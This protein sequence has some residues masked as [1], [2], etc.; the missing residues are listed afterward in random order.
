M[1]LRHE[2]DEVSEE[3]KQ[4]FVEQSQYQDE[5][6][7]PDIEFDTASSTRYGCIVAVSTGTI[8]ALL[9]LISGIYFLRA[10]QTALGAAIDLSTSGQEVLALVIN[11]VLALTTDGMMFAHSVS[12]RWALY[13]EGRLE[14]NTNIRLL[15]G[16]NQFG[17]NAWYINLVA[18]A[19]LMLSYASSSVLLLS[20]QTI[21]QPEDNKET[22]ILL[23]ATALVALGIGLVVQAIIAGWSLVSSSKLIPTWSSNPLN[24]A[25]AVMHKGDLA[26]RPGRCMLSVHQR[27]EPNEAVSPLSRQ[28]NMFKVQRVVRYVLT[29]LWS[30]AALA[31]AWPITIAMVS[32]SIADASA[33]GQ[34]YDGPCWKPGFMWDQSSMACDRN[35]VTLSLSPRAN[36]HNPN[37]ATFSYGAEAVL[38][39]LFVCLVQ[40]GQTIALHC[41]ELLV[42][43]SRDEGVWR[44]AY[45]ETRQA[46]GTQL[47]TNPFRAA[48]MSW[49]NIVLFIAKTLLHWI[50][51]QSLIPSVVIEESTDL[52]SIADSI[53]LSDPDDLDNLP[54]KRGFQFDM[55]YSRL[56]IYAVLAVLVAAFATYLAFKRSKGYQPA[57]MGHLQTL[58]DLIDDW[59]A[60]Q[61]GRMWWGDK[62][63][64]GDL[65]TGLARHAGTACDMTLLGPI[66]T[67]RYAGS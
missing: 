39:V 3:Q 8:L 52:D 53:A 16:S 44:Q 41:L 7:T 28:G 40:G 49:E 27:K 50:I 37:S 64:G 1:R 55:V 38:C 34:A 19:C 48:L 13:R 61:D 58:V 59:K 17:P 67:A 9:C 54:W 62:T 60:D 45:S 11:V 36:N 57:A 47:A 43:L 4:P 14:Y 5:K 51:G 66:C 10:N 26:H 32:K 23:N 65:G 63:S 42:N 2:E 6:D 21:I 31:I 29:L 33:P 20:N 22:P 24:T 46:R 12:L 25:A 18:F 35:Y 15:T 56:I 30:L